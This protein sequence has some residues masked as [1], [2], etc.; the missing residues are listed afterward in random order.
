[1]IETD[2]FRRLVAQALSE[3]PG[4]DVQD[5]FGIGL[6]EQMPMLLGSKLASEIG[7]IDRISIVNQAKSERITQQKG[8]NLDQISHPGSTVAGMPNREI[9]FEGGHVLAVEDRVHQP[10]VLD[11]MKAVRIVRE[12]PGRVLTPMLKRSEAQKCF[13]RSI[14]G[15]DET[16]DSAHGR[17][18]I[19]KGQRFDRG[20]RHLLVTRR[21][22]GKALKPFSE[23]SKLNL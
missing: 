18:L 2:L 11:P 14:R 21:G 1:V 22:E 3:R 16:D 8:L 15:A 9:A 7:K 10:H 4:Q 13:C 17:F 6:R 19:M 23:L 5:D 20:V 12:D